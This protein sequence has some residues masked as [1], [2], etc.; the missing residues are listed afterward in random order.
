MSPDAWLPVGIEALEDN[1]FDVVRSTGNR[2]VIAGPGAGK[3]ELLAQRAAYLLQTNLSPRP[4]RILAISFKRDAASN[5]AARVRLRTRPEQASRFDSLTFDAFAKSIVD[6]FGQALPEVW[7]P[8][9]DYAIGF[10]ND[11]QFRDFLSSLGSPPSHLGSTAD[12]A[13]IAVKTFE[14]VDLFGTPL[15]EELDPPTNV[16]RWAADE[17]WRTSLGANGESQLSFPMIGRL[18][19]LVLRT[20]P[21]L[22]KAVALTYS[23]VFL[24]EFQDT[25]QVQ[26]DLVKA[27]FVNSSAVLTAVG[28]NNQR[29]M[30]WAMAKD[31]PFPDFEGD[32]TAPRTTL[33]YNYRSSPDLV[34]VQHIL[35]QALDDKAA[36]AISQTESTVGGD[37]CAI[38]D[39]ASPEVEAERLAEFVRSEIELHQLDPGDFVV[40]VRQKAGDYLPLLAAAMAKVGIRLRNE[41]A[42]I[43]TVKLQ[44]LLSEEMSETVVLFLRLAMSRRAGAYWD[45]SRR[46]LTSLRGD[47][48]HDA[49]AASGL[50]AEIDTFVHNL[51]ARYPTPVSTVDESREVVIE[52]LNFVG[53][54]ALVAACPAYRQG[55][56]MKAVANAVIQHLLVSCIERHDWSEALDAYE[57]VGALP[58]MT[59]HKS[60]GLEYH[61]VIFIGLDDDA[62]WS[63]S[64]DEVEATAGF[65]VAFTRAKQRVLF[66]YCAQRGRRRTIAPLYELL[67]RAEI[68]L[69]VIE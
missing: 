9:R 39:F 5:L 40:M 32:F 24:D 67:Q 1:A 59:I 6:R 47:P 27:I 58:L 2:S 36:I 16:A 23:H 50:A 38:W 10:T 56:W 42:E 60:K 41:A 25:T 52:V 68:P 20:N 15:P 31:D 63:Y 34:R 28:D 51:Q 37:S 48:G 61:T 14:R 8:S 64:R 21:M 12:L 4:Q 7:R 3:T 11:R 29:I 69:L 26:Y 55:A 65:F 30:K 49:R 35:A 66:T 33:L 46:L 18:A 17:F 45:E 53:V 43:G 19:E 22:L 57:G 62:W 13:A 54:A 44:E